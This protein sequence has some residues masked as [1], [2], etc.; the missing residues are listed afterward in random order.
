[1]VSIGHVAE[2]G[3]LFGDAAQGVRGG[4]QGGLVEELDLDPAIA[5][6]VDFLCPPLGGLALCGGLADVAG[7]PETVGLLRLC[8]RARDGGERAGERERGGTGPVA[9]S[10]GLTGCIFHGVSL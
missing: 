6:P 2:V 8:W 7:E 9:D 3:P 10:G 1:M 5:A 4:E